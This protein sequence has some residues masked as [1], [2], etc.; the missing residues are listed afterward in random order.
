MH[1]A[2]SAYRSLNIRV[3]KNFLDDL[4]YK[5]LSLCLLYYSPLLLLR[6]WASR[7]SLFSSDACGPPHTIYLG[8]CGHSDAFLSL[9]LS[10]KHACGGLVF[11]FPHLFGPGVARLVRLFSGFSICIF[12]RA[13]TI[14]EFRIYSTW[15]CLISLRASP[16]IV[17]STALA[18]RAYIAYFL[19]ASPRTFPCASIK[20]LSTPAS[21]VSFISPKLLAVSL[22]AF[23]VSLPS[24]LVVVVTFRSAYEGAPGWVWALVLKSDS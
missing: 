5:I 18:I 8:G 21:R 9:H 6:N 15:C 11:L 13:Q 20:A 22:P 1:V 3:P 10:L 7:G 19:S 23:L 12:G 2:L 17:A 16:A 24:F 14:I 4:T